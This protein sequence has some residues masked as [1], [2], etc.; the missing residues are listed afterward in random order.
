MEEKLEKLEKERHTADFGL[1]T[2]IQF[3]RLD[4]IIPFSSIF[5]LFYSLNVI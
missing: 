3:N 1:F 4:L 5:I 2:S